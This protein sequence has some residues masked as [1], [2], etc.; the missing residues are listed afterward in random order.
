M[1]ELKDNNQNLIINKTNIN[2]KEDIKED[3]NIIDED[4][5]DEMLDYI[6][7]IDPEDF[8]SDYD[9]NTDEDYYDHYNRYDE[10]DE[11]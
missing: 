3:D 10:A 11:I 7:S 4:I 8:Y 6:N 5:D 1:S 2:I 9:Y